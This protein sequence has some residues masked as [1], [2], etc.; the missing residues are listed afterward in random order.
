M[1]ISKKRIR[2][3]PK[4]ITTRLMDLQERLD[5]LTDVGGSRCGVADEHKAAV[6]I[7]VDSWLKPSVDVIL[8]WN[9]GEK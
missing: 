5:A 9:R 2:K 4:H 8:R 3:L 6:R 7:Y 1:K